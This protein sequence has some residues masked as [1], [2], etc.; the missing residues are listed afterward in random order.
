MSRAG[1]TI[2]IGDIHGCSLALETVLEAVKPQSEDTLVCLGDFID[3]GRETKDVIDR[4]LQ[5][6]RQ[7]RLVMLLGN[8]EEMFLEALKNQQLKLAWFD[9]GGSATIN[10]YRYGGDIDEVPQEH[11]EFI[12]S[13]R[14]YY[15]TD[16]H[17]FVHANYHADELPSQWPVHVL[18]WSLLENSHPRPHCSGK[19]IVVGHTEQRYGEILDLDA[20]VCVDTFCHGYGWLTALEVH[21]DQT[22]QASRWGQLREGESIDGLQ[23]ATELLAAATTSQQQH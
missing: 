1:R 4:L 19:K 5:L 15:E 7:C 12:R 23:R 9:A 2:A 16:T 13:C 10:S 22:W 6:Q 18:R 3:Y 11:I 17:I 8:H 20:V 14:D 21:T